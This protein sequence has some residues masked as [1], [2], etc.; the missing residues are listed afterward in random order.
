M[1]IGVDVGAVLVWCGGLC[2]RFG[3]GV[4][5][6]GTDVVIGEFLRVNVLDVRWF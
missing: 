6:V 5:D 1:G 4:L 3:C 2:E